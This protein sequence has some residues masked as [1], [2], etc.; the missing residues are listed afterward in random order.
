MTA[1]PFKPSD[2][3]SLKQERNTPI[4]YSPYVDFQQG[5]ASEN[6]TSM[7]VD[8]L[9]IIKILYQMKIIILKMIHNLE[10]MKI[11]MISLCLVKVLQ[12]LQLLYKN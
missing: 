6:L 3:E 7:A 2:A 9:L 12:K 8:Y 4:E 5:F 10:T 11:F 1:F